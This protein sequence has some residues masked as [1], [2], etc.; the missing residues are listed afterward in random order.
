MLWPPVKISAAMKLKGFLILSVLFMTGCGETI[1][2]NTPQGF[3]QVKGS[4][5]IVNA[6]QK[7]AE[8]FM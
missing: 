3:I 8:E 5:T 4:D 6:A 2:P 1:D 7:V